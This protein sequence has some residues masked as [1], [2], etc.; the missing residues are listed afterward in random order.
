MSFASSWDILCWVTIAVAN[1]SFRASFSPF[2]FF[3]EEDVMA[4]GLGDLVIVS[5][6]R[7][8][9]CSEYL[10]FLAAS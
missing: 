5:R 9:R 2:C 6:S 7:L 3:S 4:S 1:L 8:L 10:S